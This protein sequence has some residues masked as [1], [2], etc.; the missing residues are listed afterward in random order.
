MTRP[1]CVCINTFGK[2]RRQNC[3]NLLSLG[4]FFL[5]WMQHEA[6]IT[7]KH[8]PS[9][10][11]FVRGIHWSPMD[12]PNKLLNKWSSC[13][14]F[15]R[16]FDV[17]VML[18]PLAS[19]T[20]LRLFCHTSLG[21]IMNSALF[22]LIPIFRV[23]RFNLQFKFLFAQLAQEQIPLISQK[24]TRCTQSTTEVYQRDVRNTLL[25]IHTSNSLSG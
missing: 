15:R 6:A 10:W 4:T 1:D 16:Q 19:S 18:E 11:P 23:Y 21:H 5:W 25:S 9:Y 3:I 12:S 24:H 7:W 2:K 8:F 22:I 13:R 20:G 14:W 17:I